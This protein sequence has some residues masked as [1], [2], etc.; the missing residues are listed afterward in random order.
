M[1]KIYSLLH[2]DVYRYI[3]PPEEVLGFVA[4]TVLGSP[5]G[6]RYRNKNILERI[7]EHPQ[8]IFFVLKRKNTIWG[9]IGFVFNSIPAEDFVCVRYFSFLERITAGASNPRGQESKSTK[10]G[11]L[12]TFTE[13]IFSSP[14]VIRD[15]DFRSDKPLTIYAYVEKENIRSL[16]MV[17]S[18]GLK[19][20]TTFNTYIF[21]RFKPRL[22]LPVE[23]VQ[24]DEKDRI[25]RLLESYYSGY[26]F[27]FPENIRPENNY[28]VLREKGEIVLGIKVYNV[29]WDILQIPGVPVNTFKK[30]KWLK[31]LIDFKNFGFISLEGLYVKE[32]YE[33]ALA[34]FIESICY[35]NGRDKALYW[36]ESHGTQDLLF[37][38]LRPGWMHRF[39]NPPPAEFYAKQLGGNPTE[40]SNAR[41]VYISAQLLT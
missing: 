20:I 17:H 30:N 41:P 29:E 1:T 13:K 25:T 5:G 14:E 34:D 33:D 11:L 4:D 22:K 10:K 8:N 7:H 24:K 37:K 12:R 40:H 3:Q 32:G 15:P 6:L 38:K 16:N 9:T 18:H 21:N 39:I 23:V 19:K 27:F 2:F 35:L 36:T 26:R 31:K 28:Y